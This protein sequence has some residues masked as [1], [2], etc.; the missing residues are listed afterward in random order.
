MPG[1]SFGEAF[2]DPAPRLQLAA[3][4]RVTDVAR[5]VREMMADEVDRPALLNIAQVTWAL[6]QQVL[7]LCGDTL[8]LRGWPSGL[9]GVL[10][11]WEPSCLIGFEPGANGV[12]IAV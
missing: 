5:G 12:F 6:S 11:P 1:D 9:R 8:A 4:G 7:K 2:V 10:Q 3:H